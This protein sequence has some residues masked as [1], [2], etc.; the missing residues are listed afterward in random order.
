MDQEIK[1]E[2]EKIGEQFEK[3]DQRLEKADERFKQID[4]R[5]DQMEKRMEENKEEIKRHTGVLIESL[6]DKIQLIAEQ[7]S[8]IVETLGHINGTLVRIDDSLKE[9]VDYG[10]FKQLEERVVILEE[11]TK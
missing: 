4:I 8:S 3:V 5:F 2:F 1:N 11:K 6:D 9:K 10:E 7:H